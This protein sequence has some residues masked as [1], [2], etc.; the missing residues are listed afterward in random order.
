[1][2]LVGRRSNRFCLSSMT[3]KARRARFEICTCIGYDSD[4]DVTLVY[5]KIL[6][7]NGHNPLTNTYVDEHETMMVMSNAKKHLVVAGV[8]VVSNMDL[9]MLDNTLDRCRQ[10]DDVDSKVDRI[11]EIANERCLKYEHSV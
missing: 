6:K 10:M 11:L 9:H 1:M 4:F 7:D 8:N 5:A 2:T 3:E